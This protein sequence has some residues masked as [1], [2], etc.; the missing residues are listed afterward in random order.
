MWWAGGLELVSRILHYSNAS[1]HEKY[2]KSVGHVV[3]ISID[4]TAG[5][6]VEAP[7]I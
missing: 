3:P 5:N 1:L 4:P 2:R 6:N 7:S